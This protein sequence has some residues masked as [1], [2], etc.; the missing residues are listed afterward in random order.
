MSLNQL[1][2]IDNDTII[3]LYGEIPI[4]YKIKIVII[5]FQGFQYIQFIKY[6][7]IKYLVSKLPGLLKTREKLH[8]YKF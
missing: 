7:Y 3:I 4:I 2:S 5:M 6:M 1:N 8:N